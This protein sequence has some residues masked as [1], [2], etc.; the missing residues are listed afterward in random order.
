MM[1][2][3]EHQRFKRGSGE[4]AAKSHELLLQNMTL[5]MRALQNSKGK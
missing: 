3:E 1:M 4:K 5:I 2:E